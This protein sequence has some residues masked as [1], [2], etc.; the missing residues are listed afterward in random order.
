MIYITQI[1]KWFLR[2]PAVNLNNPGSGPYP[3]LTEAV[4][5]KKDSFCRR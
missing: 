3:S 1:T 5:E 4:N 2:D